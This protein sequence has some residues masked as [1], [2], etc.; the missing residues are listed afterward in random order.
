MFFKIIPRNKI[1]IYSG[2]FKETLKFLFKK[3][4]LNR[5]YVKRFEE[6]FKGYLKVDYVISISSAR[7]GLYLILKSL[8]LKKGDEIILA[9]YNPPL[10]LDVLDLF[11]IKSVFVDVLEKSYTINPDL[12]E[13]KIIDNTKAII[14]THSEG[15]VCQMDKIMEIAKKYKLVVIE[16]CAH[17]LGAEF[18]GKRVGSI[19]DFGIFSFGYMKH[20]NSLGGGI[21]TTN[22]EKFADKILQFTGKIQY[23]SRLNILKKYFKVMIV[24]LFF[25]TLLFKLITFPLILFFGFFGKDIVSSINEEKRN[26]KRKKPE[27]LL[28]SNIQSKIALK[29]LKELDFMNKIRFVN[30]KMLANSLNKKLEI[31]SSEKNTKSAYYNFCF[32]IKNR[33]RFRNKLLLKGIDT[34]RTWLHNCDKKET[35]PVAERLENEVVY[36]S[37]ILNKKETDYIIKK[38][39]ELR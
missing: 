19:G 21:I 15:F 28:F 36:I 34:Q 20:I 12:I 18:K 1:N 32:R 39:T 5:D 35:S 13:K 9:S 3:E 4:S 33:E 8:N 23:P 27:I 17:A 11:P 26:K 29:H 7:A 31:Q 10:I 38:I 37:P 24:Y 16:D 30:Y 25:N 14:V 6:K 22:N 2:M